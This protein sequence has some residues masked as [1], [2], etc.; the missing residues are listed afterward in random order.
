VT[1]D[2][3]LLDAV[4]VARRLGHNPEWLHRNKAALIA[5]HGFPPPVPGCGNRW[6]PLSIDAWLDRQ[7]PPELRPAATPA[8]ET[9][10]DHWDRVLRARLKNAGAAP[11]DGRGATSV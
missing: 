8:A 10:T 11:L 1:A 7:M 3:A 2:R 9:D 4:G 6:D 5:A